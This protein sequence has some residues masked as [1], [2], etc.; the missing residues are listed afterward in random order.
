MLDYQ[1]SRRGFIQGATATSVLG[2]MS[3]QSQIG[4]AD[5]ISQ[6]DLGSLALDRD[7]PAEIVSTESISSYPQ[8][9]LNEK[10]KHSL[11][12]WCYKPYFKTLDDYCQ[13]AVKLGCLSLELIGPEYWPTLKKHGLTCAIAGSHGYPVGF[14]NP[15]EW[16]QC[17]ES[18]KKSIAACA[19]FGVKSVI[20]FTGMAN[21]ISPEEG[22]RN[23][24]QGIKEAVGYAEKQQVTICLEMLN[25][26]DT[27]HKMKGHPGYQGNHCDYCIDLIKQV[28]SPNL[29]LLFD[30]YHVQIMDGDVIRR[31]KQHQEYIGHIHTA[32]NPGRGEL[33][34]TQEINYP[35]IMQ[36]L[37]DVNYTGY[38]GHEYIPT[39][40]V[41]VGLYEAIQLCDVK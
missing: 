4:M 13:M 24:V 7:K 25:S 1:S 2:M 6:I 16:A 35:A 23:F 22:A 11:V 8:L 32:G 14:N 5:S 41:P 33:D 20:T 38:V 18:L 31:I 21:G 27:S 9:K 29:K 10:I 15:G 28:G 34:N 26:R 37:I 39:R 3:Y 40:N 36:A 19:E 30:I 12:N 17:T